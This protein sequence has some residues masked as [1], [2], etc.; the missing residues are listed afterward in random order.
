MT[1]V[2]RC[3]VLALGLPAAAVA[4]PPGAAP[5]STAVSSP[6]DVLARIGKTAIARG[7]LERMFA[8]SPKELR[9]KG[10]R[11]YLGEMVKFR[12]QLELGRRKGYDRNPAVLA[13]LGPGKREALARLA[14]EEEKA[15]LAPITEASVRA[16]YESRKGLMIE[17]ES[18]EVREVLCAG[19]D[20]AQALR[21]QIDKAGGVDK[22]GEPNR[23]RVREP[24]KIF[25]GMVPAD[26]FYMLKG[27]KAGVVSEPY[28]TKEGWRLYVVMALH[29]ERQ[30][31]FDE[32][33]EALRQE[34]VGRQDEEILSRLMETCGKKWPVKVYEERMS[35]LAPDTVV[36]EIGDAKITRQDVLLELG[37][38]DK[39]M[40]EYLTRSPGRRMLLDRLAQRECLAQEGASRKS[41]QDR[42]GTEL[43]YAEEK[44]IVET[45]LSEECYRHV[46]IDEAEER[47]Y[48]T[49]NLKKFGREQ[50]DSAHIL[51][52]RKTGDSMKRAGAA[53]ARV[54]AGEDFHA[55]ARELSEDQ[56]TRDRGGSLGW[57]GRQF[58]VEPYERA[59]F[60]MAEGQ[61]TSR[62]VE[63]LYGV[64]II[65]V[66]GLR[67]AAP[68]ELVRDAVVKELTQKRRDE[69]YE[70]FV[71]A[72]VR[73][74][75]VEQH[76]ELLPPDPAPPKAPSVSKITITSDGEL[77]VEPGK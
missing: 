28:E 7:E 2:L 54:R 46:Q 59:A 20:D 67:K 52:R 68:F 75:G 26:L 69:A 4:L 31:S 50:V 27:Q 45:L 58:L 23:P 37:R 8:R 10:M 17:P 21:A 14:F 41:I 40:K 15:K 60:S 11:N 48:Y 71:A 24:R 3:L 33:K 74:V 66:E 77:R 44:E 13:R 61:I 29:P 43:E 16:T 36:A 42:H 64:H 34:L 76:P 55:L 35:D 56:A 65:K 22:L 70:R 38:Y 63:S 5:A 25:A 32:V 72:A 62:P 53:L 49:E 51:F 73:E 19:R 30:K 1:T 47:R 18:V 9:Q 6:S 57:F 39:V 12:V